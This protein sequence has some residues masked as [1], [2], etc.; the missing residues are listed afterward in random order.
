MRKFR[1]IIAVFAVILIIYTLTEIDY[2]DLSWHMNKGSYLGIISMTFTLIAMI[3][4]NV[5]E[6]KLKK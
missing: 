3:L 2:K 5:S 4:T 1:T 6:A